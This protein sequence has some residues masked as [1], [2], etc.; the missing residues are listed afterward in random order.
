MSSVEKWTD[1]SE[2]LVIF[3]KLLEC[4]CSIEFIGLQK[5]YYKLQLSLKFVMN[6]FSWNREGIQGNFLL[7]IKVFKMDLYGFKLVAGL[8]N[9]L[10]NLE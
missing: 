10:D 7:F 3:S 1:S 5:N 6:L 4:C 8:A 2:L 9:L